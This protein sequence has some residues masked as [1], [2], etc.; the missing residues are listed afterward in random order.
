[1]DNIT[2]PMGIFGPKREE[3]TEGTRILQSEKFHNLY[4]YSMEMS[5]S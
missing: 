2:F 4:T 1:M 3:V 5:P